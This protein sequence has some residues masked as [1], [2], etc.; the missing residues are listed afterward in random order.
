M[1][2]AASVAAQTPTGTIL[3]TVKDPSG[4]GIPG[5]T[6]TAFTEGTGQRLTA[7]SNETGDYFVRAVLPGTY[8]ISVEK[9]GFKKFVQSGV[10][11]T[12][13][14]NVRVDAQLEVGA[15]TQSVLVEGEATLVDTRTSTVG[16]L[17]DDRRI[18][19][20]PLNA[21]ISFPLPN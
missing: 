6:V 16:T 20:L 3:G 2:L 5:A 10:S 12:S 9:D 21:A 4:L 11:V 7:S 8:S 15:V 1:L 18:V 13:F 14:S 17:V 19:D